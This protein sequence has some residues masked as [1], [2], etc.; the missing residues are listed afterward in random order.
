[1]ES[2][3][4]NDYE[5]LEVELQRP[6]I[7]K[8]DKGDPFKY[9]DFTQEQLEALKGAKGDKGDKGEQGIKGEKGEPFK[10]NDFTPEQLASLKGEKGDKGEQGEKG[11]PFRYS[12]FTQEQLAGLKGEKGDKGEQGKQGARGTKGD[13]G[14]P[15]KYED[16]TPEQLAALKGEKGDGGGLSD[17][18]RQLIERAIAEGASKADKNHNHDDRYIQKTNAEIDASDNTIENYNKA[19][20]Q[21][22]VSK[23][24]LEN[25]FNI[26]DTKIAQAS[27]TIQTSLVEQLANKVDKVKGKGLSS[28][29]F[30]DEKLRQID[31]N[32]E[33]IKTI[34]AST[35]ELN[36]EK[37]R[38]LAGE[39]ISS[40]SFTF[41]RV[42]YDNE[43]LYKA[44]IA[45][46]IYSG[47]LIWANWRHSF[48]RIER[49]AN[50]VYFYSNADFKGKTVNYAL[51]KNSNFVEFIGELIEKQT[52]LITETNIENKDNLI[53][54]AYTG[55]TVTFRADKAEARTSN[56]ARNIIA[57]K[58]IDLTNYSRIRLYGKFI[59]ENTQEA[60][61]VRF[62]VLKKEVI[63]NPTGYNP[64]VS[65]LAS[66]RIMG[67]KDGEYI[68]VDISQIRGQYNI[69]T[70]GIGNYDTYKFELLK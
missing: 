37:V 46:D 70:Y 5:L 24:V 13:K 42:S 22:V 16:F 69:G 11:E 61:Y 1:M 40:A 58:T 56:T 23:K 36:E 52:N 21:R 65:F 3:L 32:T 9:E 54:W 38:Q 50:K 25:K 53:Q 31:I 57:T 63:S 14:E 18:D 39:N 17:A 19:N 66:K 48:Y 29:D 8:G 28:N 26:V 30:T 35:G 62:G 7:L 68:E 6:D 49:L 45:V 60:Y 64:N 41:N 2:R 51:F 67:L 4:N 34:S 12:D 33:R 59:S 43:N 47:M 20:E 15:F 44:E 10:Y 27:E 55:A